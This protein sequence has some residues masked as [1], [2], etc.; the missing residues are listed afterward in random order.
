MTTAEPEETLTMPF[1]ETITPEE[2]AGVA[3]L[4]DQVKEQVTVCAYMAIDGWRFH[5]GVPDGL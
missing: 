3:E 1:L 4:A 5:L 2:E